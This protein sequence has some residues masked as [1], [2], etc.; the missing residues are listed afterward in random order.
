MK[1]KIM[2]WAIILIL[3]IIIACTNE[4]SMKNLLENEGYT[5]IEFTGYSWFSCGESDFYHSGFRAKN[6]NGKIIEGTVCEGF[7][8]KDKTIRYK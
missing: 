4:M 3:F 8:F 7:L 6:K 1:K 5:E 2:S